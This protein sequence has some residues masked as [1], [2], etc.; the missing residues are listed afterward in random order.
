ME[1]KN[2]DVAPKTTESIKMGYVE[3]GT[4]EIQMDKEA[5]A[6]IPPTQ[7]VPPEQQ[8]TIPDDSMNVDNMVSRIPKLKPGRGVWTDA[9][10]ASLA[11][12]S[13]SLAKSEKSYTNE[14]L[15]VDSNWRDATFI[16]ANKFIP[17]EVPFMSEDEIAEWGV[18][19]MRQYDND[20]VDMAMK[21]FA[22]GESEPEEKAAL[23]YM[24]EAF[25][26]KDGTF[27]DGL[28]AAGYMITDPSNLVSFGTLGAGLFVKGGVRSLA[29]ASFKEKMK[30][31][32]GVGAIDGAMFGM[33]DDALRQN[34]DMNIWKRDQFDWMQSGIS[35]GVGAAVGAGA[36][37][38][39]YGFGHMAVKGAN[40]F[41][42]YMEESVMPGMAGGGTP[43]AHYSQNFGQP[44]K[45]EQSYKLEKENLAAQV[46]ARANGNTKLDDSIEMK[47]NRIKEYEARNNMGPNEDP[48]VDVP[49]VTLGEL[50]GKKIVPIVADLTKAGGEYTG[51]DSSVTEP[52]TLMG[53]GYYPILQSSQDAGVVWANKGKGVSTKLK[54]AAD[55]DGF[56]YGVVTN[57]TEGSH[58]SNTTAV[59]AVMETIKAYERDGKLSKTAAKKISTAIRNKGRALLK[60]DPNSNIGKQLRGIPEFN[61]PDDALS[62]IDGMT[63]DAR[64]ALMTELQSSKVKE[65]PGMVNINKVLKSIREKDFA[66]G[67]WGD[68]QMVIKIDTKDT[69][70]LG[71]DGTKKHPSYDY[72]LKGEVVG[73]FGRPMSKETMFPDF[74]TARREAGKDPKSDPRAF[75]MSTPV[76][77]ITPQMIAENKSSPYKAIKSP[78]QA[79]M[80]VDAGQGNWKTS[81]MKVKDGGIKP[82]DF[83]AAIVDS[84]ASGTLSKYSAS[85]LTKE[86]KAGNTKIYQ[87][88]DSQAF[89]SLG[90]NTD[91]SW[92]NNGEPIPGLTG[93]E[94]SLNS[95][96]NNE[97][98]APKTGNLLVAKAIEDGA[99]VLDAFS[100]PVAGKPNGI[101]TSFYKN[102]GFE[103]VH[104]MPFDP[105]YYSKTELNDI[106]HLW[107]QQG[108]NPEDGYPK[109]A[110]MKWKGTDDD[111]KNF[112][113]KLLSGSG[114]LL[115][116]GSSELES[117]GG[118]S[119]KPD[120]GN[121]NRGRTG[122]TGGRTV[123][124]TYGEEPRGSG[125]NDVSAIYDEINSLSEIELKN[126]GI[127]GSK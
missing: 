112:T 120:V 42:N 102:F 98:N 90:K 77:E 68:S 15:K 25:D 92:M 53:G 86:I 119:V 9:D 36:G 50:E 11:Q 54:K 107:K 69:V 93:K 43:G 24:M 20:L 13:E 97:H 30:F 67:N 17:E 65:I 3:P 80:F 87:L 59:H 84:D 4:N 38:G 27:K 100:V 106:I 45:T 108:W 114:E 89:F 21:T 14:S 48:I 83:A 33:A 103:T 58:A 127:G 39:L 126:L 51:I 31:A 41:M 5:A 62:Y 78:R 91:Y 52:V 109:V 47:K 75:D 111:R 46:E 118:T 26:K 23:G 88:G 95:V 123:D 125:A 60:S 7:I 10:T 105:S 37:A 61:N 117:F 99:E 57:M 115:E 49:E 44:I 110:V 22:M 35:T 55:E 18:D 19:F 56:V 66:G 16:T 2:L 29:K 70:R 82:V 28:K 32:A 34:M 79:K 104:E 6:P 64:K 73:K 101:L 76:Q 8:I 12:Q 94:T 81:D 116:R 72:G 1:T 113:G 122:D 121:A 63:F 71:E 96:I 124:D 74:H 40:K 85:D